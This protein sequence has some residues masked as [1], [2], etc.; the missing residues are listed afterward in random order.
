MKKIDG[1]RAWGR[2]TARSAARPDAEPRLP[3]WLA[4]LAGLA[5]L[6]TLALTPG[7]A[8]GIPGPEQ[9]PEPSGDTVDVRVDARAVRSLQAV[10]IPDGPP[11]VDGD[12][13]DPVWQLAPVATDF[14][15]VE[16]REGA[17]ASERTE[18]RVLY[19]DDAIY[20]AIRAYDSSP[21]SIAAQLTRRD[22]NSY[23]DRVHVIIDSYFD[24]RTAFQ[25]AVNP[26]GVKLDL[27]RYDDNREDPGWDAVWDVATRTDSLGWTA[28]FR[29]P[30]SQLRFSGAEEQT[31]GINFA[32]EIARHN[33]IALWAPVS[34][35]DPGIV[36]RSGELH[37]ISNLEPGSRMELLPYSAAQ[38][39]R[40]PGDP[41]NPY[42]SATDPGMRVGADLRVGITNNLTMDLAVNPDF[43][44]VEADPGQVNLTAFE[45]F[46]P[47][48]RPFFQEGAGIFRL[49]I[50]VGDGDGGNQSLFYSRRIGRTPSGSAPSGAR[51]A[52][53]PDRTR[54]LSAGKLS[55]KT[56][57]GW[58]MGVL[59]AVTGSESIRA[60]MGQGEGA[61]EVK[62]E[63]EPR[64]SY[65]VFRLQRDFRE[66]S[67]ALGGIATGTFRDGA[68]ADALGLRREAW[69]GGM[70]LRHRFR[71]ETMELN[72]FLLGSHVAGSPETMQATQ[73]SSARYFQ[74]PDA[75][76]LELDPE[77]TSLRG[78]SGHLQL[79]KIGGGSWRYG[80]ITQ[81][82]S[83]GFE[84]N[85]LGFMP[86]TDYISQVFW[87]GYR[88]NEPGEHLRSW[89]LNTN[90]WTGW[91]FGGEHTSI[92]G[93]VNGSA[94]TNGNLNFHGGVNVNGATLD[95]RLLRGG[96]AMRTERQAN[97]WTGFNTDGR[98]DV[99]FSMNAN[100]NVR[101]EADSWSA[102]VS[103]SIRWRP[104]ER[105]T[106]RVGPSFNRSFEDRQWVDRV[107][108]DGAPEYIFGRMAQSTLA[109]TLRADMAVTPDLSVQLY[110]QPFMSAGGFRDF[111][112]VADPR[113]ERYGDRFQGLDP[114]LR[115]GRYWTD[116]QGNGEEVS[117]R[118]PR[119]NVK[120]FRS[121]AVVR[122]EYRPGSTLFLVWSQA[123]DHFDQNG[124][125]EV[126]EGFDALF[127][128]KSENVFM[129][130]ASYWLNP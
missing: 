37:G 65:S 13:S 64:T 79:M 111:R 8:Q 21:D 14:V 70:D 68:S 43:G 118:D 86:E 124:R 2:S 47:E 59:S 39:A 92:G 25:F 61:E 15:Q 3:A 28:E 12:L 126:G 40:G 106:L 110:A 99:Q 113:A 42:W 58:S 69:S 76:H 60:V 4:L 23:S 117:F 57:S 56:D 82:R 87:G 75:D 100:W 63:V 49:P 130:K 36:S 6:A 119:F 94:S 74:R 26:L 11:A 116:I 81:V 30:L 38:V 96:P 125:F 103:P 108:V 91:T 19:D 17:P 95:P 101:P 7:I 114:E 50:G 33:E 44:Q 85:D 9:T 128:Q 16:P 83:P 73:R 104:S 32:R 129:I 78:W 109:L 22:Q 71:D 18:A 84:V 10:R 1:A 5:A 41:E 122:W 35:N 31:W 120:Q 107:Q 55:G 102:G 80:S 115:E 34:R 121:N 27:Y 66:G 29:I 54:I 89:N 88:Q 48:R 24:R 93:N 46:F 72:A 123:R 97:G 45:S 67:S 90:A 52:E 112:R 20:V 127:G 77:A 53:R 51:W 105:T 98:R 62:I